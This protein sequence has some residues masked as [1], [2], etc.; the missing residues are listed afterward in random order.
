MN[1]NAR[2]ISQKY[3]RTVMIMIVMLGATMSAFW[4]LTFGLEQI[5]IPLLFILASVLVFNSIIKPRMDE[6]LQKIYSEKK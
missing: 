6:L 4:Y 3:F 2:N 5:W 1:V